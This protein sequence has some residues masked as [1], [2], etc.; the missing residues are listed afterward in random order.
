[1]LKALGTFGYQTTVR[2]SSRY[3]GAITRTVRRLDRL[4]PG[5]D[6]TARL[7]GLLA[8]A[9]LLETDRRA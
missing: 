8:S 3:L 2:K 6:D 9:G 7:H 5:N 4:L 1:M